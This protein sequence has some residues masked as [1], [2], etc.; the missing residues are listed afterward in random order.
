MTFSIHDNHGWKVT[1]HDVTFEQAHALLEELKDRFC[2]DRFSKGDA[3]DFGNHSDFVTCIKI[4]E[5]ENTI[6]FA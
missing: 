4:N 3:L 5:D 6:D 1:F 2:W